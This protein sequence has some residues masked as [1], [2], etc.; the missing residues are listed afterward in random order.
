M[1]S[2]YCEQK[3][4][5]EPVE[6]IN[7]DRKSCVYPDLSPYHMEVPLSYINSIVGVS[8][9]ADRVCALICCI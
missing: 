2:V 3:F 5:V 7:P 4:E 6:V 8:L 1:F 9:E